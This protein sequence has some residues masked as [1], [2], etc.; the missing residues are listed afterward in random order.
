MTGSV[1]LGKVIAVGGGGVDI[2]LKWVRHFS[3]ILGKSEILKIFFTYIN[4]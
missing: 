3:Y 1:T 4:Q 2:L